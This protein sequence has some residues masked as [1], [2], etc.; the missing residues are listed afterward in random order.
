MSTIDLA[1]TRELGQV[2]ASG[3]SEGLR[4]ARADR[5]RCR[6]LIRDTA[7]RA[8]ATLRGSFSPYPLLKHI[9]LALD[10]NAC[11]CL[12]MLA[13]DVEGSLHA[14]RP[15]PDMEAPARRPLEHILCRKH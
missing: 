8:N 9:S 13:I 11:D 6:A 14:C 10:P 7:Q 1:D 12:D 15:V 3:L 4:A 2:I 5:V